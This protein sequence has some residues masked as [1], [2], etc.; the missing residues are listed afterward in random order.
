MFSHMLLC[1]AIFLPSCI[2]SL[3]LVPPRLHLVMIS[4]SNHLVMT[5]LSRKLGYRSLWLIHDGGTKGI[6][7]QTGK[8]E[9]KPGLMPWPAWGGI[10][11]VAWQVPR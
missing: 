2:V 6:E 9:K 7:T 5:P 3:T 11:N 8:M 10:S 1:E 4:L